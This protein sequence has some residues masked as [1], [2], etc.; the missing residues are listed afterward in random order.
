M[1]IRNASIGICP[2]RSWWCRDVVLAVLVV[3]GCSRAPQPI[4]LPGDR[5]QAAL[6]GRVVSE[7]RAIP[8]ARVRWKGEPTHVVTDSQ[9]RFRLPLE[10]RQSTGDETL[11][12]VTAA[13]PGYIIAGVPW[14]DD[15]DDVQIELQ[16]IPNEDDASYS[17]VDPAPDPMS[18]LNC[19]NCHREIYEQWVR[20]GHAQSATNSRFLD[21]YAGTAAG[22]DVPHGWSLIEEYPEGAGV[23]N[24]C[25]APAA[26]ID[27]LGIA[28]IRS[29]DGVARAGVHCDY[30][31]KVQSVSL[32]ALGLTH[33]R[34]G[35]SL[36]R[37]RHEQLFFGPLDDVD[38]GDD[39][40]LPMQSESQFCAVCHEGVVFGV[41]VY[42][43]Y[44][45]WLLSPAAAAGVS[46]Q[47]CH[48]KPNGRMTN[49]ARHAGGIERDPSTL[50]SH[51]LLQGGR[52]QLLRDAIDVVASCADEDGRRRLSV[53]IV[54]HD[55]G[56][57]IPTGFVDRHLILAVD[58]RDNHG[59]SV[60][61]DGEQLSSAAGDLA[62]RPGVLFA[63]R[64]S[65]DEGLSP[66]PFWRAG[67]SIDD[68]RLEPDV[69]SVHDWQLPAIAES[70]RIR[71]IYRRFWHET[72]LEKSWPDD[73]IIVYDQASTIAA[74]VETDGATT[75]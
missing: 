60:D 3:A 58:V 31:H 64:L 40:Y 75:N 9:G 52:N 37:P 2:R 35:T 8:G 1:A 57:R 70:V 27:E 71:V 48:M 34:F 41:P 59:H 24:A 61:A 50:S 44:S 32:E 55:V 51:E 7:G 73:S 65:D 14:T 56:H 54:A 11:A 53:S 33:G 66:V 23:C 13:M 42:T 62:G 22:A 36:L 6:A 43:T 30:C 18:P 69:P 15:V 28:D 39:S 46:C 5:S 19:G 47:G 67:T 26:S 49:I 45:E 74:L 25:H 12:T 20:G 17:W 72:T 63:K 21:L 29:I 38:R 4:D 16:P 10:N 68:N